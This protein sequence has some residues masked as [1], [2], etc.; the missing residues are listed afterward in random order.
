MARRHFRT[1]ESYAR[2][3]PTREPYDA[4][5]IVCEGGKTEPHYFEGLKSAYR[6]SSANIAVQPMGR[7]PLSLVNQAITALERDDELTHAYCVFDQDTHATFGDA[8]RKARDHTLG[9]NGRLR[10]SVSVPCFEVWPLLHF[11]YSTAE[12]VGSGGK[13]P[14]ERAL[15]DLLTVMPAYSKIDRGIFER[16]A[17]QLDT[18]LCNAAKLV[19]HNRQTDSD[20]PSTDVHELVEYLKGLRK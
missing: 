17:P 12:I 5:L 2:R 20:N 16:L 4:V 11:R 8:V 18:A 9:K 15:A 10:L 6:L 14:G 19:R 3:G 1:K 7:D 13:T